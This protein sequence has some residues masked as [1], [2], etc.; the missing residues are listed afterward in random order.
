MKKLF[1]IVLLG[2]QFSSFAVNKYRAKDY[3]CKELQEFIWNEGRAYIAGGFLFPSLLHDNPY[4]CRD[5]KMKAV[6]RTV[7][8]KSGRC[9]LYWACNRIPNDRDRRDRDDD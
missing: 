2:A 1:F 5:R 9:K 6:T 4:I 8:S 7:R 3:T